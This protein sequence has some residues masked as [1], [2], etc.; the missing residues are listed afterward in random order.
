M[1]LRIGGRATAPLAILTVEGE[2]DAQSSRALVTGIDRAVAG[3]ASVVA[4][5][6]AGVT[7]IDSSGLGA[8]LGRHKRLAA[9]GGRLVL[10]APTDE[11]R[12]LL[13]I[14]HLDAILDVR[15]ETPTIDEADAIRAAARR[16]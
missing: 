2:I 16:R 14:T 9:V 15:D 7:F 5:D 8:V 12:R 4:L 11:T 3:G 13:T 1:S 10:V 6:V